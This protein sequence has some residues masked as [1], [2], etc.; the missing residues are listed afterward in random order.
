MRPTLR[1]FVDPTTGKPLDRKWLAYEVDQFVSKRTSLDIVMEKSPTKSERQIYMQF[2]PINGRP[3]CKTRP[4]WDKKNRKVKRQ[5]LAAALRDLIADGK[6][7][8]HVELMR[9]RDERSMHG[10]IR[11]NREHEIH[12]FGKEHDGATR[13]Y[14]KTNVLQAMA[15]AL[16]DE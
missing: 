11:R 12:L 14:T 13:I 16:G 15:D 8:I 4:S 7:K 6:I 2:A 1:E 3:W 9:V 10:A 5:M